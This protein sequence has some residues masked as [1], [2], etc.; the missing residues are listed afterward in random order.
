MIIRLTLT[1]EGFGLDAATYAGGSGGGAGGEGTAVAGIPLWEATC[2]N[3]VF[4]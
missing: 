3:L 4:I 1:R 2:C